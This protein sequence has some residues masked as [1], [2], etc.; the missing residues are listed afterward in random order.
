MRCHGFWSYA[1]AQGERESL[2][3]GKEL[4][5]TRERKMTTESWT[6]GISPVPLLARFY[7][8]NPRNT[9]FEQNVGVELGF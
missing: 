6:R 1:E 4:V 8:P 2:T 3:G 7:R 5:K 9:P